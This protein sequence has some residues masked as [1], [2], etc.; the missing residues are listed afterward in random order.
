MTRHLRSYTPAP[1][2]HQRAVSVSFAPR[3][4]EIVRDPYY[5]DLELSESLYLPPP[6]PR[7]RTRQLRSTSLALGEEPI[8]LRHKP[9]HAPRLP[10]TL[11]LGNPWH[12]AYN[13][14]PYSYE[15]IIEEEPHRYRYRTQHYRVPSLSTLTPAHRPSFWYIGTAGFPVESAER[16]RRIQSRMDGI[17]TYE[18]PPVTE[19]YS[20]LRTSLRDI[21]DKMREHKQLVDRYAGVEMAPLQS[22]EDGINRR[23]QDLVERMPELESKSTRTRIRAASEEPFSHASAPISTSSNSNASAVRGRIKKLLGKT[24]N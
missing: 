23:Y 22:V 12:T 14:V 4:V 19:I 1:I 20:S 2:R 15:N 16:A 8:Y 18:I 5:D 11:P 7:Y 24:R 10:T 13:N 6:A 17:L 9:P 3:T 21:T